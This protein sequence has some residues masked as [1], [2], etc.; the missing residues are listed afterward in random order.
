MGL[1]IGWSLYLLEDKQE[2]LLSRKWRWSQPA[3]ETRSTLTDKP[4]GRYLNHHAATFCTTDCC[5][6]TKASKRSLLNV[7]NCNIIHVD[8]VD[9]FHILG[10]VTQ[11]GSHRVLK[12]WKSL[13]FLKGFFQVWKLWKKELSV[14]RSGKSMEFFSIKERKKQKNIC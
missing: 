7:Y 12:L 13:E 5:S 14:A 6:N 1:W 2:D 3:V 11:L 9:Y 4:G 8:F 10:S